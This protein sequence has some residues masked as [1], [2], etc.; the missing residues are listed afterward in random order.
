MVR[1]ARK[2]T[3]AM[4][5][6]DSA[7]S[8]PNAHVLQ[9]LQPGLEVPRA[10]RHFAS[11]SVPSYA[12]STLASTPT[13]SDASPISTSTHEIQDIDDTID[14][15]VDYDMPASEADYWNEV[16]DFPM[17]D[18]CLANSSAALS[19]PSEIA[20]ISPGVSV[21][22]P[23]DAEV[24]QQLKKVFRLQSFRTNQ[25]EAINATLAGRDVFVLMPTGGGKSLCYQL[26]AVCNTGK[27]KGVSV[28][29]SP[30]L[31]LM[32]DQVDGLKKR[33]IDVLLWNSEAIH[34]DVVKRL[35]DEHKPKLMYVTP[36]KLKENHTA[37][38]MLSMLYRKGQLAR[39]VIDEAHCISTWGQ[40]FREAVS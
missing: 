13:I 24:M 8:R 39:F 7:S 14:F 20:V 33:S 36:E 40:D 1:K 27:T 11:S 18:S 9:K 17:G 38:S 30:L 3:A 32:K 29:V 19:V 15:S 26:P 21:K 12:A 28:V 35:N 16:D 34:E 25:L 10:S 2:S 37:K 23:Y 5:A 4:A 6:V 31:A 22:S